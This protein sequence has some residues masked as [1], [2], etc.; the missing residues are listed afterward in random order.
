LVKE[1]ISVTE[2]GWRKEEGGRR[3]EEGKRSKT[4]P[5][6]RWSYINH[7]SKMCRTHRYHRK[8]QHP[9]CAR[10]CT[11]ARR[12]A[13]RR[14]AP[15]RHATNQTAALNDNGISAHEEKSPSAEKQKQTHPKNTARTVSFVAHDVNL[16]MAVTLREVTVSVAVV[17]SSPHLTSVKVLR[18]IDCRQVV[19]LA[20]L[21]AGGQ[22]RG[23]VARGA[24]G[25][26]RPAGGAV[27]AFRAC[28]AL[29]VGG[30]VLHAPCAGGSARCAH[31]C[32][33]L[34]SFV[35]RPTDSA[36]HGDSRLT[37]DARGGVA[38]CKEGEDALA[39]C[40]WTH[41]G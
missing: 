4:K 10:P 34:R 16:Q 26:H 31:L 24:G 19:V 17:R 41:G 6:R 39:D 2:P 13:W 32:I 21:N 8:Q 23:N 3:K 18:R 1:R 20:C 30:G 22:G 27:R 35:V 33:A 40:G 36:F 28:F 38:V 9:S 37:C 29:T 15:S 14:G 11:Q 5:Q 7:H 25:A 12:R